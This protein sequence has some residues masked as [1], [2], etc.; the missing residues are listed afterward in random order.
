VSASVPAVGAAFVL[1]M[2]F[3]RTVVMRAGR[4]AYGA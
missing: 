4:G 2:L 1:H 3:T